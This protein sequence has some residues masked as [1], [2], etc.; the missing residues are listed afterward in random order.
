MLNVKSIRPKTRQEAVY[1]TENNIKEFLKYA[2]PDDYDLDTLTIDRS[3]HPY[4]YADV[5]YSNIFE[6]VSSER[7]TL[8]KWYVTYGNDWCDNEYFEDEYEIESSRIVE[9]K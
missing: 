8:N 7:F 5:E 9:V 1:V 6:R 4:L 2:Y 3:K